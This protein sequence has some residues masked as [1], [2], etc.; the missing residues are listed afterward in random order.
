MKY[1]ADCFRHDWSPWSHAAMQEALPHDVLLCVFVVFF[2]MGLL[3]HHQNHQSLIDGTPSTCRRG[4]PRHSFNQRVEWLPLDPS[5]RNTAKRNQNSNVSETPV[6]GHVHL[7]YLCVSQ[8]GTPWT[9]EWIGYLSTPVKETPRKET[10]TT[11]RAPQWFYSTFEDLLGLLEDRTGRAKKEKK[12]W[13]ICSCLSKVYKC[14]SNKLGKT[15]T[16]VKQN[17]WETTARHL[18][19]KRK[20]QIWKIIYCKQLAKFKKKNIQNQLI[21][22]H[23]I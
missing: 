7:E 13:H 18:G 14:W 23:P 11:R 22:I 6:C 20:F 10:K 16:F 1:F 17:L 12:I 5:K 21:N 4:T 15:S 9:S 19:W 3:P 2:F 8:R